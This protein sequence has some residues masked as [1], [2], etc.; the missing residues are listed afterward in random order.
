MRDS[1][2]WTSLALV[3]VA[4]GV[5]LRTIQ[6]GAQ[7]SL[8]VDEAAL[9]RNIVDRSWIDLAR[10]LDFAQ[11]APLGFLW[12]QKATTIAGT[13][14]LALRAVPFAGSIIALAL[15]AVVARRLLSP[16]AGAIA[17]AMFALGSPFIYF[18]AQAKPYSTDVTIAVALTLLVLS[19]SRAPVSVRRWIA[20]A[21]AGVASAFFSQPATF[22]IAGQGPILI[23]IEWRRGGASRRRARAAAVGLALLLVGAATIAFLSVSDAD[24]AYARDV[25]TAWFA[26]FPPRTLEDIT[27]Y[28]MR[29]TTSFAV[30]P[31]APPRLDGGLR[32]A[33]SPLYALAALAG[34]VL[35]WRSGRGEHALIVASPVVVATAAS[36][37][38]L[39][40]LGGRLS[41]YLLPLLILAAAR[42]W[43]G[44]VDLVSKH[45]SGAPG[46]AIVAVGAVLALGPPAAAMAGNLPP[47][48]LEHLRPVMAEVRRAWQPGDHAYVYYG[49]GQAFRFYAPRV[50]FGP[51]DYTMGRCARAAPRAYLQDLDRL[52]GRPRLWVL[53]T[54]G[55][56]RGE[57][58]AYV[59]DYL[60]RVGRRMSSVEISA[61]GSHLGAGALAYLYDLSRPTLVEVTEPGP[62]DLWPLACYGTMTP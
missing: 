51:Q 49:A 37:L 9:A 24:L 31:F 10:P 30:P 44:I 15:F 14:E 2:S 7:S 46:S 41:I 23:G 45:V 42:G 16:A 3:A 26:P 21:C 33:A 54:H 20:M 18:A 43:Q 19:A 38:Q 32:Y 4:A 59:R 58:T 13:G 1:R 50:G 11:Y 61:R 52:R 53:F 25:W 40:P 57:E 27:W 36:A 35:W 34:V 39:Y 12:L 47:F 22:V 8:W 5:A 55:A 56:S 29:L 62:I 6:Y 28:W 48:Y 17:I 60:D